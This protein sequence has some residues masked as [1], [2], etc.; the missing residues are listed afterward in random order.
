MA[1]IAGVDIPNDKRGEVSLTYI[2]GIGRNRS[3]NIL[4]KAGVD[5]NIKVKDWQDDQLQK[6]RTIISWEVSFDMNVSIKKHFF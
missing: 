2:Y 1:R 3:R 4:Q 6:I 5:F